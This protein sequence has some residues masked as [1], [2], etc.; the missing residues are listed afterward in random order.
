MDRS[1]IGESS[2]L[3]TTFDRFR[4]RFPEVLQVSQ[5]R[6]VAFMLLAAIHGAHTVLRLV[7]SALILVMAPGPAWSPGGITRSRLL[8]NGLLMAILLLGLIGVLWEVIADSLASDTG[9]GIAF[10]GGVGSMSPLGMGGE[11]GHPP[12]GAGF[13]AMVG[14]VLIGVITSWM[15]FIALPTKV[16][17]RFNDRPDTSMAHDEVQWGQPSVPY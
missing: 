3:G 1:P 17:A 6:G 13:V 15:C 10:L 12:H 11:I 7:G 5:V 4:N 9:F 8:L 16:A 14:A 2:S